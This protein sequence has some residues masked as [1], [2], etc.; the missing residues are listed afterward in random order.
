MQYHSSNITGMAIH[1][2]STINKIFR[3]LR[4]GVEYLKTTQKHY[5]ETATHDNISYNPH[6]NKLA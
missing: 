2:D 3:L 6:R 5:L 4:S 1:N